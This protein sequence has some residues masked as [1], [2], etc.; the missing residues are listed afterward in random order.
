M[1][2]P[3]PITATAMRSPPMR[4]SAF[5]TAAHYRIPALVIVANNR[6]HLN[7]E[8][9]QEKFARRRGRSVEN[10]WVGQR[11][12]EPAIDHAA[13]ARAQGVTAEG[14]VTRIGDLPQALER[15]FRVVEGGAPCVVDVVVH[16]RVSASSFVEGKN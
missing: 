2:S 10:A 11:I 13:I 7:D 16:Q 4:A 15:A 9:I 5:W 8:L 1:K 14:P 3:S 6:S 12:N